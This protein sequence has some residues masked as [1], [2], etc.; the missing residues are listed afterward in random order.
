MMMTMSEITPNKKMDLSFTFKF[1][2]Y[3]NQFTMAISLKIS[4]LEL[5][6]AMPVIN[7]KNKNLP[8]W[9]WFSKMQKTW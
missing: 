8:S 7:S 1:H 6:H 5:K 9:A 3:L 4:L 2:N